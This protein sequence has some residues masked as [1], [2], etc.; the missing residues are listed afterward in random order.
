MLHD[1]AGSVQAHS[2]KGSVYSH[3]IGVGPKISQLGHMSGLLSC[4]YVELFLA[5]VFNF[6]LLK[7]YFLHCVRY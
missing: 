7:Q 5:S 4:L 3:L 1:A 6:R 2:G